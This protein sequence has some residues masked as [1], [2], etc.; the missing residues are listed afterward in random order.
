[1]YGL[2][3]DLGLVSEARGASSLGSHLMIAALLLWFAY[4]PRSVKGK[5]LF[6]VYFGLVMG[7]QILSGRIASNTLMFLLSLLIWYRYST[8]RGSKIKGRKFVFMGLLILGLGLAMY[9]YRYANRWGLDFATSAAKIFTIQGFMEKIVGGANVPDIRILTQIMRDVP[10]NIGFRY[11]KTFLLKVS[12]G[13]LLRNYWK[14]G[15]GGQ[16]PPTFMGE[17]Y[18]NWGGGGIIGGMFLFGVSCGL[19]YKWMLRSNNPWCKFV[20][21]IIVVQL[22][23]LVKG[24]ITSS[25]FIILWRVFPVFSGLFIY[26]LLVSLAKGRKS[27]NSLASANVVNRNRGHSLRSRC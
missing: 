26:E 6:W 15:H 11:G 5:I 4:Y 3:T 20:Y 12:V 27:G 1:M 9:S 16:L 8:K 21:A 18:L 2:S 14:D 7:V 19:L 24:E 25:F 13:D 17:L 10:G 22:S 23:M